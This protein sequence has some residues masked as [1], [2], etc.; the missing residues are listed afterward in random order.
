MPSLSFVLKD[1]NSKER[2]PINLLFRLKTGR[3]K[4]STKEM[5]EP[6]NWNQ[7]KQEVRK[8]DF[9]HQEINNNLTKLYDNAIQIFND[10]V[11]EFKREPKI[12]KNENGEKIDE[13]KTLFDEKLFSKDLAD[14][15]RNKQKTF[16]EFFEDLIKVREENNKVSK[17]RIHIYNR[18]LELLKDY[19]K[20]TNDLVA[21][22]RFDEQFSMN[23]RA[24]LEDVKDYSANTIQK[25]FKVIRAV[26]NNAYAKNY[27]VN[28][29]YKLSDFMPEGEETFE[30]ALTLEEVEA[31]YNYNFSHNR[32]LERTRDLFVVGCFTGLRFSDYSRL[33]K[34][35]LQGRFLSIVQ[36]KTKKKNPLPVVIPILEPVREIFEKYDYNLPKGITNQKMNQY[37]KELAKETDLFNDEV[38]YIKTKGGEKVKITQPRYDEIVTHTAR[39]TYCSISY[40]LGV[41][42]QSIMK[43]SGHRTEKSFLKYLKISEIDHAE[44]T[45][46]IWEAYYSNNKKETGKTVQMVQ[47]A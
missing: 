26:L 3:V 38:S 39:R 13:L 23:F 30:I 14:T 12:Y 31:L 7:K 42:T 43:I 18:T 35:H 25:N 32:R 29:E 4:I 16:F 41:P 28:K 44:R 2:T 11:E 37:L 45:L 15:N 5:V 17:G 21:F 24:Y 8:D 9:Y 34:E 40:K 27:N 10:F 6:I 47:T 19:Q 33:G 22:E 36:Q 46:K 20:D 1:K